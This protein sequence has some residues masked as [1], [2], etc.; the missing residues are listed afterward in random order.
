MFSH[1]HHEAHRRFVHFAVNLQ[2]ICR[3]NHHTHGAQT[4]NTFNAKHT[5]AAAALP[6]FGS[7]LPSPHGASP[8]PSLTGSGGTTAA[9]VVLVS[10]STF[11]TVSPSAEETAAVLL[12][13]SISLFGSAA[14]IADRAVAGYPDVVV[15]V[16]GTVAAGAGDS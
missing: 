9:A 2:K 11:A 6:S 3:L 10:G 15:L 16:L 14:V 8:G 7:L 13:S 12:A 5:S 1:V 4:Q